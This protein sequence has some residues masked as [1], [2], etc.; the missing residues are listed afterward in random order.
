MKFDLSNTGV[1][2]SGQG[3]ETDIVISTRLRLARNIEGYAFKGSISSEEEERLEAFLAPAILGEFFLALGWSEA[4]RFAKH[5]SNPHNSILY[6]M[7]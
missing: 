6:K 4:D 3:E 5:L 1:W 7:L 2:L